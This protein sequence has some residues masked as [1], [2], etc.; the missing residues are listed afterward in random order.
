MLAMH[1]TTLAKNGMDLPTSLPP[2]LYPQQNNLQDRAKQIVQEAERKAFEGAQKQSR[3]GSVS[4]D[5]A[6]VDNAGETQVAESPATKTS[7]TVGDSKAQTNG[8]Q[9]EQ[10][11]GTH[12]ET[13]AQKT[14][15]EAPA[16][17]EDSDS[18]PPPSPP[19]P[20]PDLPSDSE[21]EAE[22]TEAEA[23]ATKPSSQPP[24][25]D[26]HDDTQVRTVSCQCF[27]EQR[28]EWWA[29]LGASLA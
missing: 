14:A 2:E 22:E 23:A 12:V 25:A 3:N 1:L 6:A 27:L 21:D 11:N 9:P 19:P 13:A 16:G 15:A 20:M 24:A 10:Q 18:E 26:N 17:D 7:G 5:P 8:S 29:V 28:L 4:D